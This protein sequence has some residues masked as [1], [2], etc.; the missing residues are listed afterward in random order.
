MA[1]FVEDA[2]E[3]LKIELN[4]DDFDGLLKILSVLNTVNEKQFIYDYMFEP[5]R[6]IVELLK[7]YNF[8]FKDTVLAM[9]RAIK[10]FLIS[11]QS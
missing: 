3:A 2:N 9:V 8:E 6:D 7:T 5:L 11:L 1:K 4:K 10:L